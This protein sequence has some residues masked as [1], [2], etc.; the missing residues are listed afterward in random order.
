MA[1]VHAASVDRIAGHL[2][3]EA[4]SLLS[5]VCKGVPKASLTLPGPDHLDRVFQ[6]P[7]ED[8]SG[9]VRHHPNHHDH[10]HI[11]FKCPEKDSGC[12]N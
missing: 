11:R 12:E 7:H 5:H 9:L 2:G 4:D 8:G 1:T 6:Y 10:F 3:D